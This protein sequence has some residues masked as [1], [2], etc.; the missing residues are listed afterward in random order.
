MGCFYSLRRRGIKPANRTNVWT[1][2]SCSYRVRWSQRRRKGTTMNTDI[3]A[4]STRE[5]GGFLV[6]GRAAI[7]AAEARWLEALA[8]FDARCGFAI[9]GHRDCV[10][11]LM[12][13]CG[14]ARSTAKDRLRV[15]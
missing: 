13:K 8:A 11:W 14:M 1:L 12:H 6:T 9:D 3:G 4:L 7:D 15:A 2:S 10:S 5:L